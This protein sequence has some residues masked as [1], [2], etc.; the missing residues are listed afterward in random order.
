MFKK[1]SYVIAACPEQCKRNTVLAE[2]GYLAVANFHKSHRAVFQRLN[3]VYN[4]RRFF[5]CAFLDFVFPS[6][7][8]ASVFPYLTLNF[9][10]SYF[11]HFLKEQQVVFIGI[12]NPESTAANVV[13]LFPEN[14]LAPTAAA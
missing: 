10:Y 2:N 4:L 3:L 13:E 6:I 12:I 7:A 11:S 5:V 9:R 8:F 14:H 1:L